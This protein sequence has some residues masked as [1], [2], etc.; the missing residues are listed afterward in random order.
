MINLPGVDTTDSITEAMCKQS[1]AAFGDPDDFTDNGG[2]KVMNL[3]KN[4][5]SG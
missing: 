2:L 1:K 4:V 3:F 5:A